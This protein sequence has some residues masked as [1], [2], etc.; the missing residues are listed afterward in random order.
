MD[1]RIT[2]EMVQTALKRHRGER[3]ITVY[4]YMPSGRTLRSDMMLEPT[5]SLKNQL[6]GLL[7]F[8]NVKM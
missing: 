6:I 2:M 3:L 4:M 5:G 7:G 8:D 1:D